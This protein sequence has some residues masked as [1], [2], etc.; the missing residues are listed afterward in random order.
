MCRPDMDDL[1][2]TEWRCEVCNAANSCLDGDC[3]FCDGPGPVC[4]KCSE[5]TTNAEDDY[6]EILCDS[7]KDNAAERAY[8]RMQEDYHAGDSGWPKSLLE[9]QIEARKLK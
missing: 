5:P 3:Q 4:D 8:M 7:C 1:P 2:H 9:Q 6:G